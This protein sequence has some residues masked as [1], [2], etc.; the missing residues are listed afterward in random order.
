MLPS[1]LRR[2]VIDIVRL[3]SDDAFLVG[4]TIGGGTPKFGALSGRGERLWL[5]VDIVGGLL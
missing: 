1:V 3:G 5:R 4:G 2:C